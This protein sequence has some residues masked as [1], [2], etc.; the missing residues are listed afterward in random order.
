LARSKW[1]RELRFDG[2]WDEDASIKP[3]KDVD[4]ID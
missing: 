4:G 3:G 2:R 1:I